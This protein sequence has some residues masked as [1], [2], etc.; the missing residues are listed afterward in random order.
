MKRRETAL[1]TPVAL[2]CIGDVVTIYLKK[3]VENFPRIAL[4]LYFFNSETLP[5]WGLT[6]NYLREA[7]VVAL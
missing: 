3:S 4:V 1:V 6:K 5:S 7:P 2:S